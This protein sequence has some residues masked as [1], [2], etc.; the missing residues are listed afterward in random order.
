[1]SSEKGSG[2]LEVFILAENEPQ[3]GSVEI[4]KYIN[5]LEN[6]KQKDWDA[7]SDAYCALGIAYKKL[8]DW[9]KGLENAK[10]AIN[11]AK[12]IKRNYTKII[13]TCKA[14]KEIGSINEIIQEYPKA[15]KELDESLKDLEKIFG[16][17]YIQYRKNVPKWIPKLILSKELET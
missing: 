9:T 1:M 7:L 16:D 3:K 6:V 15:I 2:D 17:Q 13:K 5:K 10:N 8:E 11:I 14:R 4:Q 12:K